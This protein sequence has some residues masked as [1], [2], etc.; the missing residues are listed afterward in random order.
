M[1]QNRPVDLIVR[2]LALLGGATPVYWLA[3]VMLT[4]FHARL[5]WLPGPGR[6]DAYLFAPETVTGLLSLDALLA[7]DSRS[8]GTRCGT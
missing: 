8:F 2:T 4:I 3:I 7:R 5:G 6:L 1:Y